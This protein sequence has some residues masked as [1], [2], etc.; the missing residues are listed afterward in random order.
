LI[1]STLFIDFIA[2]FDVGSDILSDANPIFVPPVYNIVNFRGDA[3]GEYTVIKT[4]NEGSKQ[5]CRMLRNVYK[6]PVY[7]MEDTTDTTIPPPATDPSYLISTIS[8]FT[9]SIIALFTFICLFWV[10]FSSKK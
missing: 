6:L 9:F 1:Y 5:L 2:S 4:Y 3:K 10:P 8:P 7:Y